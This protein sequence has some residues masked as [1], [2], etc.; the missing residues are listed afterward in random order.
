[1]GELIL[2]VFLEV[3]RFEGG[4]CFRRGLRVF[5]VVGLVFVL[6]SW[7]RFYLFFLFI[8]RFFLVLRI[9]L[10]NIVGFDFF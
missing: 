4:G 7:I 8:L 2:S 6:L 9:S 1:M 3:C 10:D 5:F